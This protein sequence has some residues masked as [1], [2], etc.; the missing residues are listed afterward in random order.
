MLYTIL[1]IK[2]ILILHYSFIFYLTIGQV[3]FCHLLVSVLFRKCSHLNFFPQK[4]LSQI[5][6]NFAVMS[7]GGPFQNGVL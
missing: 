4:P 7:L 3:S 1:D 2:T 5:K 6:P